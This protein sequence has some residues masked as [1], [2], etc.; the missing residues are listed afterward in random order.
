[1][2]APTLAATP[3][4]TAAP[5]ALQRSAAIPGPSA[6]GL[7]VGAAATSPGGST[8]DAPGAPAAGAS[9]GTGGP[10]DL[11]TTDA[12]QPA[13]AA[14]VASRLAASTADLI[15]ARS[16]AAHGFTGHLAGVAVAPPAGAGRPVGDAGRPVGDAD[17][18]RPAG[19]GPASAAGSPATPS[20]A[21]AAVTAAGDTRRDGATTGSTGS[22]PAE[23]A[24]APGPARQPG[25][26]PAAL[27]LVAAAPTATAP[28]SLPSSRGGA[29]AAPDGALVGRAPTTASAGGPATLAA[30]LAS[31][32]GDAMVR[33]STAA[34]LGTVPVAPP[35]GAPRTGGFSADLAGGSATRLGAGAIRRAA[36]T[37]GDGRHGAATAERAASNG[38]DL[39]A[40]VAARSVPATGID[41]Q[42][43]SG[44]GA[45]PSGASGAVHGQAGSRQSTSALAAGPEGQPAGAPTGAASGTSTPAI[46]ETSATG[47]GAGPNTT[48]GDDRGGSALGWAQRR[49]AGGAAGADADGPT[50]AASFGRPIHPGGIAGW[51]AMGGLPTARRRLE[52]RTGG[53]DP[54]LRPIAPGGGPAVRPP[55]G[56]GRNHDDGGDWPAAPQWGA[57]TPAGPGRRGGRGN[58]RIDRVTDRHGDASA[59]RIEGAAVRPGARPAP[60]GGPAGPDA[61]RHGDVVRPGGRHADGAA[62]APGH[63]GAQRPA[64]GPGSAAAR[65]TDVLR[66]RSADAEQALPAHLQVL[67]RA[68]VGRPPVSM[69]TGP[70]SRAALAAAGKPAATIGRVIHLD[71]VPD[72]S[73]RSAEIVAHELVH[74]A[75]PS[76]VPRFFGDDHHDAEEHRAERTGTLVRAL[77]GATDLPGLVGPPSAGGPPLLQRTFGAEGLAV[78]GPRAF[79]GNVSSRVTTAGADT[80]LRRSVGASSGGG[81]GPSA[82][83]PLVPERAGRPAGGGW[84]TLLSRFY[85]EKAAAGDGGADHLAPGMPGHP[86]THPSGA[87]VPTHTSHN[88]DSPPDL[89]LTPELLDRIVEALE[90]RV[91]EQLERR[92]FRHLPGVV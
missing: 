52:R 17:T 72:R 83:T 88:Q 47:T 50:A 89:E 68:L 22:A 20:A 57:G 36:A 4:A 45:T 39:A 71:H 85:D 8:A 10:A 29:P 82:P 19:D 70:T 69:S 27:P 74:A 2:G 65:F 9:A 86:L 51:S 67:A 5:E 91:I 25:R 81:S 33:R 84:G 34:H 42:P 53:S 44:G 7:G 64:S 28:A 80:T 79:G 14:S 76:S 40:T 31:T 15:A 24:A 18:P 6:A 43:A 32:A 3:P 23:G 63:H 55:A 46:A 60:T 61:H 90:E 13:S 54:H 11:A 66:R 48:G 75:S 16:V 56:A 73:A 62:I 38:V 41:R 37:E 59:H 21:V 49:V 87:P 78:T 30:R 35:A 58:G 1:F 12:G 77:A 26:P 92:S